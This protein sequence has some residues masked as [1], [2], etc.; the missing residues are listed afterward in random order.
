MSAASAA[1]RLDLA[2]AR[3]SAR[4]F[5]PPGTNRDVPLVV[6]I[7]DAREPADEIASSAGLEGAGATQGFAKRLGLQFRLRTGHTRRFELS[8]VVQ[9]IELHER[10]SRA[11]PP[12]MLAESRSCDTT[13]G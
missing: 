4:F 10:G 7:G 1:D 8:G 13:N 3:T 2:T 6:L 9:R 12:M 11:H 5:L